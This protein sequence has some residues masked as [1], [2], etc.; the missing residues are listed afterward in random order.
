MNG[1]NLAGI[2]KKMKMTRA[3]AALV[4]LKH[5]GPSVVTIYFSINEDDVVNII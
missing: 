2:C 1:M 5:E 3:E 4:I